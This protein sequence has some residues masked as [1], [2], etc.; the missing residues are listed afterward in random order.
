[1]NL[2]DSEFEQ[3]LRL[4]QPRPASA[5]LEE[6]IA[7]ALD[8]RDFARV[9]RA[10]TSAILRRTQT[11]PAS[12]IRWLQGL[13][14]AVAGAAAAVT[15][16]AAMHRAETGKIS[17]VAAVE[18]APVESFQHTEAT[19]ELVTAED[20]G[21]V[22]A[23]DQEPLRQVRYHSLERHVWVNPSTGARMEVEIPRE[24]VRFVS[25]AMQ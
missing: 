12:F 10:P 16:I 13:G 11:G 18:A 9:E 14:W 17:M 2:N 22:L 6:N 1:M 24:D 15:V 7:S 4:L 5:A 21:L 19:E 8:Q 20:E 3:E 23:T 25:V